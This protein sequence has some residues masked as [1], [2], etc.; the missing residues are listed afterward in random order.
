MDTFIFEEFK[1]IESPVSSVHYI[2][3]FL[4]TMTADSLLKQIYSVPKPKWT[5]LRNR[6]LQNW[7]K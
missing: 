3:N 4:D 2:P 6:R 5:Q 1:V 7:G